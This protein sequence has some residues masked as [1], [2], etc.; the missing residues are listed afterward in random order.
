MKS[1][2]SKLLFVLLAFTPILSFGQSFKSNLEVADEAFDRGNFYTAANYYQ[3]VF[4]EM[5]DPNGTA[6]PYSSPTAIKK[7]EKF[8]VYAY[9]IS[10]LAESYFLYY[11]YTLAEKWYAK[12][13][14]LTEFSNIEDVVNYAVVLRAN[15][16]YEDAIVMFDR[17]STN[18]KPKY[19]TN[20]E[21]KYV[22]DEKSKGLKELIKRERASAV[23]AANAKKRP[24]ANAP[25]LMDTVVLNQYGSSNY[26]ALILND[27]QL[28][29]TTTRKIVDNPSSRRYKDF[30]NSFVKYDIYSGEISEIDFGFGLD[31][32]AA[33][34]S[35]TA[36][37]QFMYLTS[38]SNEKAKPEYEIYVARPLNDSIWDEPVPLN[39]IVNQKGTKSIQ[40]FV[41]RDGKGLYF[42]SDRGEG[43]GGLDLYYVRLD[44]QGQPFGKALNLGENI[45]TV[46][47]D[48]TPYYDE[49]SQT[50]Y[51]SSNGWLGMGG[52]DLFYSL[53]DGNTWEK[54]VNLGYP[55][56]SSKDD[57]Y[58]VGSDT[59]NI[60]YFS[61]DRGDVCCYRLYSFEMASYYVKGRVQDLVDDSYLADVKITF[62]DSTGVNEVAFAFTDETGTFY[63]PLAKGKQYMAVYSKEN[64]LDDEQNFAM[65]DVAPNDTLLLPT[66]KLIT[67]E[68]GRAVK[69]DNIFYDF[70]KATL[71]PE[72]HPV[73][74][75]LCYQLKKYPYLVI[76]IG[77]HTDNIGSDSYNEKLS[78]RRSQ[79]VVNYMISKGIPRNMIVA[80]GYGEY[81]PKVPNTNPDGS[82]NEINRQI[83]RRTEF[84]VLE[85]KLPKKK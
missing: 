38:W 42:S 78:Q 67:T 33:A 48:G 73:L 27:R 8:E 72:S 30:R 11:D 12:S 14:A 69:L 15:E 35:I 44:E 63:A 17:A 39:S 53:R 76:E 23:F 1:I 70:G 81:Q 77:S 64:F 26:A 5:E 80:K 66:I 28:M 74:D 19:I 50:L 21:G 16:K 36:D 56:N 83:N 47:D 22:V 46:G 82:D 13:T 40:P 31:R 51:F 43:F 7:N 57:A 41:T 62:M 54:P 68:P 3:K 20:D 24:A 52:L 60:G 34:P 25:Y 49:G 61:S 84:K 59:S 45:N 55:I 75:K 29:L 37:R 10:R 2:F 6:F 79:S 4:E 71:R 85:S 58:P 9:T 18:Y 32:N 65:I